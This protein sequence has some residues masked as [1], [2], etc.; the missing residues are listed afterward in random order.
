MFCNVILSP[1]FATKVD[2]SEK[3]GTYKEIHSLGGKNMSIANW[4]EIICIFLFLISGG[5]I[6]YYSK[7]RYRTMTVL[8][9]LKKKGMQKE[10]LSGNYKGN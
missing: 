2:K 6:W 9:K 7:K 4:I 8:E 1:P 3:K 10:K 5:I